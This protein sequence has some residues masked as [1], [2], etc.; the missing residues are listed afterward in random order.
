MAGDEFPD[1]AHKKS[2]TAAADAAAIRLIRIS[3]DDGPDVASR[4]LWIG[5]RTAI[6]A[7]VPFYRLDNRQYSVKSNGDIQHMVKRRHKS[8]MSIVVVVIAFAKIRS[9]HV[10]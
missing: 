2:K 9:R 6:T 7:P 8:A 4:P 5:R 3:P 10:L 1:N